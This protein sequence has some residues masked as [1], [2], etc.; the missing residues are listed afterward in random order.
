L[1]KF[2]TSIIF[3][4]ALPSSPIFKVCGG[5]YYAVFECIHAAYFNPLHPSVSFLFSLPLPIH[6][7]PNHLIFPFMLYYYH[8]NY[9]LIIIILGLGSTNVQAHT[10]FDFLSWAY[11]SNMM[12][13]ISIT[14]LANHIITYIYI[15]TYIYVY[16]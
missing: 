9:Y 10:I 4:C 2:A 16:I 13:S 3:P 15:Y 6:P 5:F 1:S 7:P 8:H 12:I 11:L 14:F